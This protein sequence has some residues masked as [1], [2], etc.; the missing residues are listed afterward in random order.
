MAYYPTEARLGLASF[1]QLDTTPLFNIG[2]IVRG[3][4]SSVGAGL[5]GEF[6]YLFGNASNVVGL[7]H[8][9]N[10]RTGVTTVAPSTANTGQDLCVSMA[11]NATTTTA[12]WYQLTGVATIKK[13]A[14]KISPDSRMWFSATAGRFFSTATTGKQIL[15]ARTVNSATIAS[16]T[17]TVLCWIGRP[18]GQGQII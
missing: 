5:A 2:T 16:T 3:E 10:A 4:D 9:F 6:I 15:K 17:S 18:F 14:V 1:T 7:L 13:T 11:T 8:T 12:S